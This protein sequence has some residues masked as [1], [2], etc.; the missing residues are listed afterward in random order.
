MKKILIILIISVT[1]LGIFLTGCSEINTEY[2]H[3]DETIKTN[4]TNSNEDNNYQPKQDIE[5]SKIYVGA[6][7]S[8][9]GFNK[10]P[11]PI[12]FGDVITNIA[13]EV[14]IDS[15]PSAIWIV[16]VIGDNGECY[17]E[18]PNNNNTN[19]NNI[20]F[21]ET[22]KHEEYLNHFDS[23]GAKV[24]LQVEAG[25]ADME[26]LIKIILSRYKNHSSVVGFGIDVEWFPSNGIE[27]NGV[28]KGTKLRNTDLIKY[29]KLV[30]SFNPEYR[31][32]VKHWKPEY[33]GDGPVS[34]VIYIDDSQ[35]LSSLNEMVDEFSDWGKAFYPNDV[36]FQVG[37][38]SDYAW[39]KN[40]NNP[41]KEISTILTNKMNNQT[42]HFY[43]VDFT[44]DYDKLRY[45]H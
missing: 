9:Y 3:S 11:S 24:F 30:K 4:S 35:E 31:T 7:A 1:L 10:F 2:Q 36:G 15:I 33:C 23:I 44:L 32:F 45:I 5:K 17:L 25:N 38:E 26:N 27:A 40:L 20:V 19:Y 43:W 13:S 41:I 14:N 42:V 37:Y 39:W 21:S 16:G 29:D 6:R 8:S 22:D 34:D 12:E 28:N 18:F